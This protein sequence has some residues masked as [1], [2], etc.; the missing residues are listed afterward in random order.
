MIKNVK[1]EDVF[2][3]PHRHIA[4]AINTEGFNDAGFAGQVSLR[5]APELASTGEKELGEVISI[6]AGEKTFHG[7]VCH[8]LKKGWGDAPK[9]ITS[10]LEKIDTDEPIAVVLMGAGMIGQMS[11]ADVVANAKAIHNAKKDIILYCLEYSEKAV[12]DAVNKQ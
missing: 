12:F 7:L 6:K 3:T 2:K 11:G 8:S 5:F 9:A 4:F 1:N 10:C